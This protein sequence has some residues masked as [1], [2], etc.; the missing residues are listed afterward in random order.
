M[1]KKRGGA[2]LVVSVTVWRLLQEGGGAGYVTGKGIRV[3][4]N[5]Y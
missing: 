2:V 4:I 1:I 5:E 3:R